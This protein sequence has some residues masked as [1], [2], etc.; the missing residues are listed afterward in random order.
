M[1]RKPIGITVLMMAALA[2]SSPISAQRAG[3]GGTTSTG[4]TRA[5]VA[6]TPTSTG[7]ARGSRATQP[8]KTDNSPAGI[9]VKS[10]TERVTKLNKA[11][12]NLD[13][14][15]M[16]EMPKNLTA[17]EREQWT[18]QGKW[19]R[20]VKSRYAAYT[21]ELDTAAKSKRDAMD[22]LASLS[23][24]DEKY[25]ELQVA[26]QEESQKF[27][28]LSKPLQSRHDATLKAIKDIK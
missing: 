18:E 15:S 26:T 1:R 20:S 12:V 13:K 19:I 25:I 23:E 22:V 10:A 16:R 4:G 6:G 21:Q 14:A 27:T 2:L 28:G 24:L 3:G 11:I 17:T 9:A 8:S 7:A 5:P